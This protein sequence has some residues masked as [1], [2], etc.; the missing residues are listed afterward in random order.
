MSEC[1]LVEHL[2]VLISALSCLCVKTVLYN[3][4]DFKWGILTTWRAEPKLFC[5]TDRKAIK[6]K[7]PRL[8][9][10]ETFCQKGIDSGGGGGGGGGRGGNFGRVKGGDFALN[11]FCRGR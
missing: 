6:A 3:N 8:E 1:S 4:V 7:E 5:Q 9:F 10:G 2:K 11:F